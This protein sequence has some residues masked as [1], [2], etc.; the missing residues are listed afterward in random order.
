MP[1]NKPQTWTFFAVYHI[2]FIYNLQHIKQQKLA[3]TTL[4]TS[5]FTFRPLN[6]SSFKIHE[7]LK[8]LFCFI[9]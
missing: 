9:N 2:Y 6:K 8:G 4:Q 7:K 5:T 1:K 3:Q